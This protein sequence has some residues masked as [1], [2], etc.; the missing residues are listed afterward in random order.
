MV[1]NA[2]SLALLEA[3]SMGEP[4]HTL[5]PEQARQASRDRR[6]HAGPPVLLSLHEVRD[7]QIP[8]SGGALGSTLDKARHVR[9]T[10]SRTLADG[11][12]R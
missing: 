4:V 10:V 8:G 2:Q 11:F 6:A 12:A 9:H 1:L 5:T 3:L 7:T